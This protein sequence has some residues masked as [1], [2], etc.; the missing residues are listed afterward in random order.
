MKKLLFT[1]RLRRK[2]SA[3]VFLIA[4]TSVS[5]LAQDGPTT[6]R[7]AQVN[8]AG[9]LKVRQR[10][11]Q[12]F[13]VAT[14]GMIV[15]RGYRLNLDSSGQAS[16]KCADGK[17]H[18]LNPG[19]QGCPCVTP[20]EGTIQDGSR[21]PSTRGPDTAGSLFP[22]IVSPRKTL[23]LTTRPVLR[24]SP[25]I[26]SSPGA[27]VTYKV[28]IVSDAGTVW[29]RQVTSRTEMEY[30]TDEKALTRGEGY[31]LTVAAGRRT[32]EEE[33]AADLGF[34]VSAD[35]EAKKIADAEASIDALKLQTN[36]KKFFIADLYAAGGLSS[37]AIIKLEALK[38]ELKEL[39]VLRLLGDLYANAGLHREAATH[40]E[41]ALKLPQ[42]VS[43]LEGQA[44]TLTSLGRSYD[45]LKKSD[46]A[47]ASFTKA[48]EIFGKLGEQVTVEKLSDPTK[49]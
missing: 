13:A 18:Q 22:V 39:A 8:P 15:R 1:L 6:G 37:E 45:M 47:Q 23:L 29:S 19:L 43:D 28:S 31:K 46:Q 42:A 44:L 7:V 36:E 34:S 9:K 11:G 49:N 27:A 16:V 14:V 40:Y 21:I 26:S 41:S 10:R 17:I 33:S 3:T 32:S 24:W 25:V 30:P 38:G 5:A 2:L 4:C 12:D 20:V 35:E 48:V